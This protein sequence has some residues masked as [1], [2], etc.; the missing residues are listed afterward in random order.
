MK[1][2]LWTA[3]LSFIAICNLQAQGGSEE[4]SYD[5]PKTYTLSGFEVEGVESVT[6][7]SVILHT[8]LAIGD[9]VTIPGQEIPDAV[10]RLWDQKVFSDVEIKAD[11]IMGDKLFLRIIVQ[12]RP[13]VFTFSFRGITKS[14]GEDLREKLRFLPGA[15]WTPEKEKRST[16][17]VRNFFME[18]GFYNTKVNYVL[19]E[20]E[21]LKN[22]SKLRIMV[23]KGER[24][25]INDFK[26][27]GNQDFSDKRLAR[28]AK[29]IKEARWWRIW[30]RS[31]Y[32][33][34]KLE[35]AK[36][37]LL[38]FYRSNGYRDA[39][40]VSDTVYNYDE[41]SLDIELSLFEGQQYYIRN[42]E[43]VGNL[44]Y[45]A[46][47]LRSILAIEK[48]DIYDEERLMS[49]L[50]GDPTSQDIS[51]LYLDDGYLFF[52]VDPVEVAVVEDSIDLE[53]RVVEGPQ[54]TIR[55]INIE[56][57]TKT[58]DYVILRELRTIPGQKFSRAD[59]IR[60]QREIL[61][62]GYFN[63]ENLQIQP[64]PDP[65]NGT[66]DITY[67]VEEKPSDQLQIQGGWGGQIR[68]QAGNV[69]AG[70][71][72]GT[73]QLG[74]NN[75]STKK[76]FKKGAWNPIPAGDG[77]RLNLAVQMN[78]VG[79]Q[80]YSVSFLEPWLGGKKPNSLGASVN[81]TVNQ[82]RVNNFLM[83]TLGTGVDFGTRLKW[84]DDFF[85]A[86][87]SVSYKYYDI[88]NGRAG[89]GALGF[90]DAFIN[91]FSLRQTFD[92]TSIDA[93]IYP[94][95]GSRVTFS[96]E[97]TPPYSLFGNQ[98]Y[99]SLGDA[100]KFNFLEYH[101]WTFKG[102]FFFEIYKNLVLRPRMQFGYLG[103]Y[104]A[105]YGISP[106][107]RYYL[108]GSGLG[109]FNFYGYEYV[110]LRGYPDNAIGPRQLGATEANPAIGGNILS[111]YT[112]ELRYPITLNQ[113]APIWLVG[114][115]EA[116]NTWLG[117]DKFKPFELKR[118]AGIG[119]RVM[120]PMVGLLGVDWGYGFD[121]IHPSS[122]NVAGS[123]FT[124]LIG[125][126]F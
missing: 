118:S 59:L 115:A 44:K 57:N 28:K 29:E 10:H 120:L 110:G 121:R 12:E 26:I 51:G 7:N 119:A 124:F 69:I 90:D 101:K 117:F 116:G 1:R 5:F 45:T 9:E 79:W 73:V 31:K 107:E 8:G 35:E 102:D 13:R 114:F 66:V 68:D 92:R 55:K 84:P 96:V 88:R 106:F 77:Q 113:A 63:Q 105:D 49:R 62:L 37:N 25:R 122:P 80:N 103:T 19:E 76:F 85:R 64:I 15:M 75:F 58:S 95:S 43:F 99:E 83:R 32:V 21:S 18:K 30:S 94:R 125:Q 112:L 93:P 27:D 100:E 42:I 14:Q 97:A 74:F 60:S 40:I 20:E 81:Y 111:K 16:R 33:P 53:L 65:V 86:M 71:F 23:D 52:R 78:G 17:I 70:G 61:N 126:E 22:Q 47:S 89:F 24:I 72:V 34:K 6:P 46:D 123:N 48:G 67:V 39:E 36:S 2:I 4:F 104:N 56:G 38:A 109:Q 41:G 3:L 87:T 54:A 50:S 11:K 82:N 98:D 108:G 91:V